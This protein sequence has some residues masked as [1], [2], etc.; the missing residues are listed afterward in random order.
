[1]LKRLLVRLVAGRPLPDTGMEKITQ[2]REALVWRSLS[3]MPWLDGGVND[4]GSVEVWRAPSEWTRTG[5]A[6]W[7]T[8]VPERTLH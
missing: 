1:M 7:D 2:V 6:P 4:D 3:F 5:P 8:D